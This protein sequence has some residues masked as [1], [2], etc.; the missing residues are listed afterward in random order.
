MHNKPKQFLI[1]LFFALFIFFISMTGY[2]DTEIGDEI[3]FY[4]GNWHIS[5]AVTDIDI[6]ITVDG[7]VEVE[8]VG[9][10]SLTGLKISALDYMNNGDIIVTDSGTV[11]LQNAVFGGLNITFI[12]GHIDSGHIYGNA[13]L[14]TSNGVLD[15]T[16]DIMAGQNFSFTVAS[17]DLQ[18]GNLV[19]TGFYGNITSQ[20]F[21]GTGFVNINGY[22]A[23]INVFCDQDN[24]M[25][26][27]MEQGSFSISGIAFSNVSLYIDSQGNVQGSG[28]ALIPAFGDNIAVSIIFDSSRFIFNFSLP[29][30]DING[31]YFRNISGSLT[32]NEI[33][34]NGEIYFPQ[35]DTA[36]GIMGLIIDKNGNIIDSP[37]FY[38][39]NLAVGDILLSGQMR[40]TDEGYHI[41]TA[42]VAFCDTLLTVTNMK[43]SSSLELLY[44]D[45]ISLQNLS[46]GDLLIN[47]SAS[48]SVSPFQLAI[49]G[50]LSHQNWNISVTAFHLDQDGNILSFGSATG[51]FNIDGYIFTCIVQFENQ[52]LLDFLLT[53]TIPSVTIDGWTL[54]TAQIRI[55]SD[56]FEIVSALLY[57]M[58]AS[59]SVTNMVFD[60]Q[61]NIISMDNISVSN[62]NIGQLTFN[63][64]AYIQ[65]QP[66]AF[67]FSGNIGNPPFSMISVEEFQM[68]ESG[69]IMD[70][71]TIGASVILGDLSFYGIVEFE[72]SSVSDYLLVMSSDEIVLGDIIIYNFE[73]SISS[74]GFAGT[75]RL[76]FNSSD[77]MVINFAV[78]DEGIFTGGITDG[79]I[80][81]GSVLINNINISID[82]QGLVFAS[83]QGTF[84]FLTESV[85]SLGFEFSQSGYIILSASASQ[86]N[87]DYFIIRNVS[88]VLEDDLIA[89]SGNAE[90]TSLGGASAYVNRIVFNMNG[91]FVSAESFGVENLLING[92]YVSGEAT[93]NDQGILIS[94]GAINLNNTGFSIT[95]LL[96]GWNGDVISM[97][98]F[99]VSGLSIG[100]F[101]FS[102]SAVLVNYPES[103]TLSG[104]ITLNSL[105]YISVTNLYMD[106]QWNII[107]VDQAS[108]SIS[109]QD[110]SISGEA[111]LFKDMVYISGSASLPFLNG[112]IAFMADI[113]KS[114]D[115]SGIFNSGY[116]LIAGGVSIPEFQVGGYS[117][118]NSSI[119]FDTEGIEGEGG[120]V[121]PQT[122]SIMVKYKFGWDGTFYHTY[123][124]ATG[125]NIPLGNS[126][127][128]LQGAGGGLY[129][130]TNPEEWVVELYG[131]LGDVTQTLQGDVLLSVSDLGVVSGVGGLYIRGIAMGM[132]SFEFNNP[133]EVFTCQAWLGEDPNQGLDIYFASLKGAVGFQKNWGYQFTRGYGYISV[134]IYFLPVLSGKAFLSD[135]GGYP[136]SC[137][138]PRDG[139]SAGIEVGFWNWKKVYGA[140]V[141]WDPWD[142]DAFECSEF[143]DYSTNY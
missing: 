44:A 97:D 53:I 2:S 141:L 22:N 91:E 128:F 64:S 77:Y 37:V 88:I 33:L 20:G 143:P 99:A 111:A 1:M 86:V 95:N 59:L 18:F 135:N 68:N 40:I 115:G 112:P 121:L 123:I 50:Q 36:Y 25:Y 109:I 110:V 93:V 72:G 65:S 10:L 42:Q 98:S 126:G 83:A 132:A 102:G 57:Y 94:I 82:K 76:V 47:G 61:W 16:F 55:S 127:L 75:G 92:F 140:R 66:R 4:I 24:T 58:D 14:N 120:L 106:S 104:S 32:N 26:A 46:I 100:D 136:S 103:L 90:F 71:G 23:Q 62:I 73:G 79:S 27:S 131:M 129:H 19:L 116:D 15:L 80:T 5:G 28:N 124:A 78:S 54:K 52:N 108:A 11:S 85:L 134:N 67:V 38:F 113:I 3:D 7:W 48:L 60:H 125:M 96:L 35:T 17:K 101:S 21:F 122:A 6:N 118:L 43:L 30:I 130:Y 31:I 89:I 69:E 70:A 39:E 142:L 87:L 49:D 137:F 41:I 29:L 117:I 133:G 13:V 119:Y 9:I 74:A 114:E 56:G 105:G 51:E 63:G 12:S 139:L 138:L 34:L 107:S 84:P 81:L 8:G 45:S